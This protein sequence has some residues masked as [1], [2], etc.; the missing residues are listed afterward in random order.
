MAKKSPVLKLLR[1]KKKLN[2]FFF[3]FLITILN[4]VTSCFTVSAE[5]FF[6]LYLYIPWYNFYKVCSLLE[7]CFIISKGVSSDHSQLRCTGSA[8]S[9]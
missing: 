8:I 5:L 4:T 1:F 9:H 3:R 2:D 7:W 6:A